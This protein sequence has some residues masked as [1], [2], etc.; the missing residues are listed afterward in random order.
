[1]SKKLWTC[2]VVLVA[3]AAVAGL[4]SLAAAMKDDAQAAPAQTM[5]AAKAAPM[6]MSKYLIISPHTKEE[7]LASLD[8]AAAMGGANLAKW[9][10]GCMS[11]DHTGYAFVDASSEQDALKMVPESLRA[12]AR[13]VKVSQFTAE[14]IKS[15]HEMKH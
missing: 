1:M 7:C 5:P 11:G 13:A 10:W 12:K 4:W 8:A 14:Q 6:M 15:F 3:F 9:E 2:L